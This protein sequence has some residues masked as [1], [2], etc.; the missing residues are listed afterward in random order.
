MRTESTWEARTTQALRESEA[1]LERL[2][3]CE[4]ALQSAAILTRDL[5]RS[6][7]VLL[8]QIPDDIQLFHRQQS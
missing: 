4:H 1:L 5:I 7:R 3:S 6:S 8:C 2:H